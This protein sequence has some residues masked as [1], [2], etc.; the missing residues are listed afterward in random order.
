M[1]HN[2]ESKTVFPSSRES[3]LHLNPKQQAQLRSL[4]RNIVILL[5]KEQSIDPLHIFETLRLL[6]HPDEGYISYITE[7]PE[8]GPSERASLFNIVKSKTIQ[9]LKRSGVLQLLTGIPPEEYF[10]SKNELTRRNKINIPLP[11]AIQMYIDNARKERTALPQFPRAQTKDEFNE[12][13]HFY[14][15]HFYLNQEVVNRFITAYSDPDTGKHIQFL[16]E[17]RDPTT[18]QP[19]SEEVQHQLMTLASELHFKELKLKGVLGNWIHALPSLT[20]SLE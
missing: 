20:T 3:F 2:Q 8:I 7:N 6:S 12:Q 11:P 15:A 17:Y 4:Y 19:L 14:I 10:Y 5:S 9:D 18:K 1:E 16:T 13:V